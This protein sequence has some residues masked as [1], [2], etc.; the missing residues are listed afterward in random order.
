MDGRAYRSE[1]SHSGPSYYDVVELLQ[2][3]GGD[4]GPDLSFDKSTS[5]ERLFSS[6]RVSLEEASNPDL[7]FGCP[8]GLNKVITFEVL[9]QSLQIEPTIDRRTIPDAMVWRHPDAT[10]D[11]LRHV[12]GSF[13][14]VD[15]HRLSAHVIKLRDM[16]EGWTGAEVQEEPHLDVR[17]TLQR[18]PFYCTPP[19]AAAVVIPDPT[20]ED[21]AVG[22][23]SSKIV[24]KAEAFQKRKAST[25]G[26]TL[27]HVTKRTRSALAQSSSSTTRPSLFMGDDDDDACGGSS[28]AL[29][30]EGSNIRDSRGKGV[31]VDDA[32]FFT[33]F[34]GPYYATYPED[35]VA[36]N[37]EFTQE[38]W[39]A[40]Y[41]PTFGFLMKEVFKDPGVWKTIV[42]QFPTPGE[43]VRVE[44]LS[45]DQL[46]AKISVM[47]YMM[48]SHGDSRLKG[49]EE[50]VANMTGFV[51]QASSLKKQVSGLN[52]KL[53]SSD[54]SFAMS[55]AKGKERKKKIKSLTKSL[56]NLHTEVA[57]LSVA[58]NQATILEAERDE[59]ILRRI[60]GELLSLAASAR[61][62]RGFSMHQKKDE[63][64][65]VLKN[66]VNFMPG[67][68]DRLA[69]ASPH[70]AQTD[71]AFLNKISEHT[72][73]PLLES[74]V[75]PASKS[76][77]LS[78]NVDLTAS[79]VASEHNE[80]MVTAEVDGSGPKITD[81]TIT[82]KS[83]HA[84]VQGMSVVLDDVVELAG[85]GSRR[86]S[87]SPNDVVVSL[88]AGEKG[89]GLTLFS[90]AGEEAAINP[91]RV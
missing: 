28:V 74:T 62:K 23:P 73:E 56:D 11:D 37:C 90:I 38:E 76:L 43:M 22:T 51:L 89:D 29:A 12:A 85:V 40:P 70:V 87:S 57:R 15:V 66:M 47:H 67:A 69:E 53:S 44:S 58:L 2:N 45:D 48:M 54:A 75:T 71:Y 3:S 26:A 24:A 9:C 83:R 68:Q 32:D 63:F 39:D 80:E 84:F 46:T 1:A 59:E 31:M 4:S 55:K 30:A 34:V 5:S 20:L 16:S 19:A 60:Q 77:E 65:V 50:K 8:L 42:D 61:F 88:F 35:S 7:S 79:I 21:L 27:S 49:Y 10:I 6:A 36:G 72:V 82:A 14:T 17:P 52:D 86:V 41:R 81:D 91:S 78:A 25:S 64:A 13:N 18:L 33:F